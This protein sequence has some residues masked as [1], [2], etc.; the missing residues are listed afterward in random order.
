M[1][2]DERTQF[3][4]EVLE[5]LQ[6]LTLLLDAEG[7][8]EFCNET[9]LRTCGYTHDEVLGKDWFDVFVPAGEREARRSEH[10]SGAPGSVVDREILTRDGEPRLV[11]WNVIVLRGPDAKLIGAA[12][13]GT[14]VTESRR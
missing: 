7:R 14:D 9:L 13:I 11:Q 10:Q 1:L 6:F 8:I 12:C 4:R 2:L 3:L 5:G